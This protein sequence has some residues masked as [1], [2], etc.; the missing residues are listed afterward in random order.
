MSMSQFRPAVP[1]P[2]F[3]SSDPAMARRLERLGL[4]HHE[5]Q[6]T[7]RY[8]RFLCLRGSGPCL[9]SASPAVPQVPTAALSSSVP[10]AHR[11]PLTRAQDPA[12]WSC[13]PRVSG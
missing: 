5:E 10:A 13:A 1:D 11:R 7:E 4:A 2:A 8:A 12:S 9:S 3:D 6:W